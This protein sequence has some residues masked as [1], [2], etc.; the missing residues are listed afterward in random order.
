MV[1]KVCGVAAM[2]RE[3]FHL[4]SAIMETSTIPTLRVHFDTGY[5]RDFQDV[6]LE[7]SDGIV[8]L[9]AASST[10]VLMTDRILYMSRIEEET[11]D[12]SE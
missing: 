5:I 7:S 12:Q 11:D 9:F 10:H 2:M 4:Q 6:R 3:S 8:T 1:V